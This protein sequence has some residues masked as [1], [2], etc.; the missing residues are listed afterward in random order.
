MFLFIVFDAFLLYLVLRALFGFGGGARARLIRR[1]LDAHGIVLSASRYA[2]ASQTVGGQRFEV[3]TL[4]LDVEVPGRPPY[5]VSCKP[6]IPR[7]CEVYPGSSLDLR[8]DPRNPQNIAVVGPAGSIGWMGAVPNLFPWV[9][10][11]VAQTGRAT[12]NAMLI[13]ALV[14]LGSIEA[15]SVLAF[16]DGVTEGS[17]K[18]ESTVTEPHARPTDTPSPKKRRHE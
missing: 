4:Q 5:E 14:M 7:I 2:L 10:A 6:L 12:R 15:C 17:K 1:G 13:I 8:V 11:A 18:D 16:V 3:R 9:P